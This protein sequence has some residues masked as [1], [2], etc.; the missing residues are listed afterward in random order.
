MSFQNTMRLKFATLP[1]A[2]AYLGVAHASIALRAKRREESAQRGVPAA[3][4]ALK[5]RPAAPIHGHKF[6]LRREAV[7]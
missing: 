3:A 2:V 4:D 5:Q 7:R 6:V 1:D